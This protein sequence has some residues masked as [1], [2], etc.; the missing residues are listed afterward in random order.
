MRG[1]PTP[2]RKPPRLARKLTSPGAK[3]RGLRWQG[4]KRRAPSSRPRGLSSGLRAQGSRPSRKANSFASTSLGGSRIWLFALRFTLV[5]AT[6]RLRTLRSQL[7]ARRLAFWGLSASLRTRGASGTEGDRRRR[8][9]AQ[10]MI[11]SKPWQKSPTRGH[12]RFACGRLLGAAGVA[13]DDGRGAAA[14]RRLDRLEAEDFGRI[15]V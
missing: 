6:A 10:G 4:K 3:L 2:N 1:A 5:A 12:W 11:S 7:R 14:L 13:V 8:R 15:G 9:Y